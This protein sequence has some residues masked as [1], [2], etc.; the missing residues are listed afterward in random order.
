MHPILFHAGPLTL[1]S[2]GVCIAAA[3]LVAIVTAAERAQR[4]GWPKET[5]YDLSLYLLIAS[6]VGSRL[7]YILENPREFASSPGEIFMVWKGGLVFYGGFA[8][9]L[10][11]AIIFLKIHRRDVAECFDLLIPSVALGHAI[12]RIGCLLNGC[13]F[14]TVSVLPWAVVYPEGSAAYSQQVYEAGILRAGSPCTLPVHPTQIYCALLELGVFAALSLLLPRKKF[15]GQVFWTY[16]VLYCPGRFLIEFVR[17][18]NPAVLHVGG[19]GLSLPQVTS[20]ILLAVAVV[21]LRVTGR[22]GRERG[23]GCSPVAP[24]AKS[25]TS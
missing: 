5:I 23:A 19:V 25:S 12:G 15:H 4:Y 2:F 10:A 24:K 7:F 6:I 9:A 18:D 16:F 22:R 1:Y 14:G 8:G 11:T 3:C 20:L 13:C 21:A 17:A